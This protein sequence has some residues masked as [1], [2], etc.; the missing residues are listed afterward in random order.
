[1]ANK[2][3]FSA[4]I[5]T[6]KREKALQDTLVSIL[7]NKQKPDE[8][9]VIDDGNL[10][11]DF[12]SKIDV[13]FADSGVSFLY[14]NKSQS[15]LRRGLSES[16]NWASEIA[17]GDIVCYL[18]DDV[19]LESDYFEQLMKVWQENFG[20]NKLF[21]ISGKVTNSRKISSFEKFYR[22]IFCL[23]S[24][25][26]WDV[27]NVGFQ[28]WDNSIN[29]IS[30]SYYMEGCSSSYRRAF[31]KEIPFVVFSGGR[32]ALEDV[33]HCLH[34]KRAGYHFLFAP[35]VKL[36]HHQLPISRDKAYL[37]GWK[38]GNNRRYIFSKHS[39]KNLKNFIWFAWAN[40]GWIIKK[41]IVLKFTE[42]FGIMAGLCS[43]IN[44]KKSLN[45]L[46][47]DNT[48][49]IYDSSFNV[50]S[51]VNNFSPSRITIFMRGAEGVEE[52]DN[53][54]IREHVVSS[55]PALTIADV[56]ML[57]GNALKV[58]AVRYPSDARHILARFAFRKGWLMGLPGLMRR[59]FLGRV[60]IKGIYKLKNG[61]N[62]S[63]YWILIDRTKKTTKQER[64][65]IPKDFGATKFFEWL[66]SENIQYVVPRF[67]E[68]L[69]ELHREGGDLDLLI[70]DEDI[71]KVKDYLRT[72]A[73]VLL[74]TNDASIPIG[75][76][77]VT[78][79]SGLPYYPP[80]LARSMLK[81]SVDGPAG[82]KIPNPEDAL[83]SFI[84]HVL[85][86]GKG[87]ATNIPSSLDGKPETIPENDY[88]KYIKQKA[89]AIGID[90][91]I[92][93]EDL[94]DYM[95]SVGWRPKRDTLAKIAEKNA[96]VRDRFFGNREHGGTGL[97][98]FI[99]KEKAL[100]R[101][102]R[103]DIIEHFKKDGLNIV[104][105]IEF[106]EGQKKNATDHIR[107]GNWTGPD[108]KS[109]GLLPAGMLIATDPRCIDLP[110]GYAHDYERLWS[111]KRK[112]KLRSKFDKEGEAS[113]VHAADNSVEAWEYIDYCFSDE[114][115]KIKEE[116]EVYTSSKV[117]RARRLFSITYISHIIKFKTRDF[118]TK[119]L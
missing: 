35:D 53:I 34:A 2:L 33:E 43:S 6:Y 91:K 87:Y 51:V 61:K 70:S 62:K 42:A 80:P 64:F 36:K 3:S 25:Y 9:L 15:G 47:S 40:I 92:T 67:Y 68:N 24:K 86:H 78:R 113:I 95:E 54:T 60:K 77:S 52:K 16:K 83:N 79:A 111:K 71:E 82:S 65:A 30:K 13:L 23:S 119:R 116:V 104:R 63:S 118:V 28:V 4:V 72:F 27:T 58:L 11:N 69:P 74:E 103:G 75:M 107:G 112:G 84:Y 7:E 105:D 49:E 12:I 31:L 32:T 10:S 5:C 108:G 115:E 106:T 41:I 39:E 29:K 26:S 21:G 55:A 101:G 1:M 59:V 17:S 48:V 73:D 56:C 94:D 90:I 96:W 37:S 66:R 93:M 38:E 44:K 76:H 98:V 18:D 57:D 114:I 89:D 50:A 102:L 81:N 85:Y 109:E 117:S 100:E 99:L 88:G 97:T 46:I 8:V 22:K 45:D 20:N 19:I 110:P 14:K